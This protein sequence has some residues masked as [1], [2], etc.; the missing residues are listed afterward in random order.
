MVYIGIDPGKSGGMAVIRNKKTPVLLSVLK[1]EGAFAMRK[2]IQG[3]QKG[4]THIVVENVPKTIGREGA[5]ESTGFVL[6]DHFGQIKGGLEW[7]GLDYELVRP[8]VWQNGLG[9]SGKCPDRKKMLRDFACDTFPSKVGNRITLATCDAVLIA[10]W[11]L[12]RDRR[13]LV[14]QREFDGRAPSTGQIVPV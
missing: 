2:Y 1:W 6:G 13:G 9:L 4:D 3:W 11:A 5:S 14:N 12:K 7:A 8:F 10:L